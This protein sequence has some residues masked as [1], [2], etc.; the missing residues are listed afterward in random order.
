MACRLLRTA[1]GDPFNF[2]IEVNTGS[3]IHIVQGQL[4]YHPFVNDQETYPVEA[5]CD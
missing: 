5:R 1:Q 4:R 3:E 2:E